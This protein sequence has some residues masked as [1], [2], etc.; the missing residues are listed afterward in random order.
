MNPEWIFTFGFGHVHPLTG[1]SL[2][3]RFVRIRAVNAEEARHEMV[4]RWGLK[5]AFQYDSEDKAGV[6]RWNL[7][8]V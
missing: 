5:W 7:K 6:A 2:A 1:E 3:N 8:E 4:R